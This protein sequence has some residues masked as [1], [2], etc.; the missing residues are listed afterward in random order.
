MSAPSEIEK[1]VAWCAK[2]G[3]FGETA[4]ERATHAFTDTL[5]CI[6]AGANDPSTLAARNAFASGMGSSKSA[7]VGGGRMAPA[8]AALINAVAA[9]ALDYDDNFHGA[10]SHASA[11]QVPALLATAQAYNRSG[12]A[13]LEAYI[14]GLEAQTW[15]SS[16]VNPSHYT[17]GWHATSTVGCIGTAAG[18]ARLIGLDETGIAHALSIAVSMASGVKGQFG[19]P[20]KPLHAGLAARNAIEAAQLSASGMSGRLDVLESAQGFKVLYGGDYPR[21]WEDTDKARASGSL[22]IET[23]GLATKRHPCCGATHRGI[24]AVLDLKAKHGFAAED[25]EK[26]E[27]IVTQAHARNLSYTR[28]EN[29]MQARFSMQYAVALAL[30]EGAL[31]LSDFTQAGVDRPHVRALLPLTEISSYDDETERKATG[32]LPHRISIRLKDG[33]HFEDIRHQAK[34]DASIPFNDEE[35]RLKFL[36]CLHFAGG[37]IENPGE[38]F[39]MANRIGSLNAAEILAFEMN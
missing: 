29:E 20:T 10:T 36:D 38:L 12:R 21:G 34:G 16:G 39:Q 28:P 11:V 13:L 19:T 4:L 33:R 27:I 2:A 23:F 9:H 30:L 7:V 8:Q 5:G 18:V 1:I 37:N 17:A 14:I 15:V 25:V 3:S 31:K 32:R 24:D 6:L 22:A 35:R 26:I